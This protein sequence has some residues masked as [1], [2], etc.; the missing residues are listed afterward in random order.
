MNTVLICLRIDGNTPNFDKITI[1]VDIITPA[2][3][4]ALNRLYLVLDENGQ[5]F[6]N[7]FFVISDKYIPNHVISMLHNHKLVKKDMGSKTCR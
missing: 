1:P 5:E 4:N 7:P 6:G 3:E 2:G